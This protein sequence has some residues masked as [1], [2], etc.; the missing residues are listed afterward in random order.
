MTLLNDSS[1]QDCFDV[2]IFRQILLSFGITVSEE[3]I[4]DVNTG[5]GANVTSL[6]GITKVPT[7]IVT[8]DLD[9]YTGLTTIWD[10]VGTM[11]EGD[12][13]VFRELS[14]LGGVTYKDL[15]TNQ[16]VLG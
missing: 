6:Y 15:S 9:A 7:M 4:V 10:Q 3:D 1:C 2:A 14:A 11:E 5:E 8:G 13:F 16:T 12:A